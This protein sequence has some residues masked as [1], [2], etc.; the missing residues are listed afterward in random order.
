MPGLATWVTYLLDVLQIDDADVLG[1]SWGG[2][3]AQQLARDAAR[4]VHVL[5]LV[6]TNF[7]FGGL[8]AP[9]I[10]PLLNFILSGNG[11]D[12]WKLLNAAMGGAPGARNPIGAVMQALNPATTPVEGYLRQ[13]LAVSGW[14]STQWLNE[15]HMPTLVLAGND[16]PYVPTSTSRTLAELIPKG[17]LE[18][19][20]G[21]GH[22]LPVNQPETMAR[23]VKD[24]LSQ[25]NPP[26]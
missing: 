22:L 4:R 12:P 3:L 5:I 16:D 20:S 1:Y 6:S 13:L 8:P 15:L 26:R 9:R 10:L 25:F 19:I 23:I 21:G 11:D 17:Q 24:F 7:G 18:L 2:V 14:T